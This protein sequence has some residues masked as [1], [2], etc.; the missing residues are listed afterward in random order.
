MGISDTPLQGQPFAGH[1]VV[2]K[3]RARPAGSTRFDLIASLLALWFVSGLFLDGWAHNHG[4]VDDTFFTPWHAIMYTGVLLMG[5]FLGIHQ[6]RN[7]SRG[8]AWGRALPA[9]YSTALVGVCLFMVGGGFDLWWHET[10]G[11]ENGIEAL[12]SPAHLF[13]ATG[14]F[15][16][17]TGALRSAWMR[18]GREAAAEWRAALP[19]V[20][21][22]L[23]LLSLLTFFTMY[24]NTYAN[25]AELTGP[26]RR[27]GEVLIVAIVLGILV[28][29]AFTMGLL[30]LALRHWRLPPGAITLILSINAL[31]MFVVEIGD[32]YPLRM[33]L[34]SVPAAGLIG[35]V[36][37]YALRPSAERPWTLR[38]IGFVLPVCIIGGYF[39][40]ILWTRGTWW[41]IHLWLGVTFMS[42]IVGLFLSYLV[43]PPVLE[44]A[45][46]ASEV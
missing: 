28:Q 42:G 20:L 46:S 36:L 14:A 37:V 2:S 40:A 26:V 44:Q 41:T 45:G 6:M 33:V 30:L 43:L 4:R 25:I 15:L 9:G 18:L 3:K 32:T 29:M 8:Y 5:L 12:I 27:G 21:S 17:L 34:L 16:F 24:A 7:A 13:L 38:I 19:L 10:F 22:L 1:S 31:A 39:L 11:F 23:G 35:D